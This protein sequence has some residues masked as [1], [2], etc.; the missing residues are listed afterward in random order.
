MERTEEVGSEKTDR[1]EI[2]YLH[3]LNG[4][5]GAASSGVFLQ[6]AFRNLTH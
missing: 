4:V 3:R 6:T 5:I 1:E 2:E